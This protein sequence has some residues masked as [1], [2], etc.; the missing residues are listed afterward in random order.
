MN[1]KSLLIRAIHNSSFH[2]VSLKEFNEGQD[3]LRKTR[4]Y[5]ST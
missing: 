2:V 5:R 3:W 4:V 1:F